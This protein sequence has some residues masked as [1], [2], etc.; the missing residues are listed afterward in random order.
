MD[1]EISAEEL[2]QHASNMKSIVGNMKEELETAS[3]VMQRTADSFES[4]AAETFRGQ[5]NQLKSKFDLFYNE[6]IT[7]ATFLEKTAA[8]YE[9]TDNA[10]NK[11]AEEYLS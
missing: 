8:S 10:I 7:Y 2:R 3:N 5:Y 4:S 1:I 9:Q 11:A 6:M